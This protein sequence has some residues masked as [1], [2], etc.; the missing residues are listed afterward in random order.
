MGDLTQ[1]PNS[2]KSERK[3]LPRQQT[4]LAVRHTTAATPA[5][6]LID[7]FGLEAAAAAGSASGEEEK[8][9]RFSN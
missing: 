1:A 3:P 2:P 4:Q 9:F 5:C 6:S 7:R 8:I